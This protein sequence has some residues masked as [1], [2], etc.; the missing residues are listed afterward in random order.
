[1]NAAKTERFLSRV[2]AATKS[3]ILSNIAKHYGITPNEAYEEI[4]S[5][6]AEH[7]LDYVTGPERSAASLLMKRHGIE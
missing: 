7:L 1:M 4:T 6:D 2:D 5:E 3:A